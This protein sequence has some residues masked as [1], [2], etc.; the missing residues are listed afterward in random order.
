MGAIQYVTILIFGTM[1]KDFSKHYVIMPLVVFYPLQIFF[2]KMNDK[3]FINI[4][5]C[6]A[7]FFWNYCINYVILKKLIIINSFINMNKNNFV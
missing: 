2:N 4:I 7:L 5:N 6:T 1:N 3:F